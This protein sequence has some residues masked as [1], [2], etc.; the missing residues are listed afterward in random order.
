ML[1][2]KLVD[3]GSLIILVGVVLGSIYVYNQIQAHKAFD[4]AV[5]KLLQ[6]NQAAQVK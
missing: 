6:Q 5:L 2:N 4:A 3:L 1:K